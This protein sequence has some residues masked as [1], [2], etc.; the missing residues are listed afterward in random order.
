MPVLSISPFFLLILL[1]SFFLTH[2]PNPNATAVAAPADFLKLPL[3]HKPPFSSPSQSLSSDTHR[4]SL[5]FS[6]PNPTLKSPLIS[7]A[8]TGSGQYFVDIRLGTPPQSLLLVAD[9]GSDLVWVKCSACRNCSHHP[10]SSAFLPRHSSSFSPFHCFDPHCRLLPHAPHHLCNHTRL[11]SPCRFLYSYADGS[12]SSGFF[13]KETTTLKSL[14]GSEIHLKGLSFGCGFRISGPSV[15]GAQFNGA[16]G[17]MGLGRG[18]ISFSSQL[19]RR[20]GNKFSYCLMD[21]TLSPPPTSFLM[22][23]GGLH[24][25]P[26][27]NA[28]KISYTPLQINPLSPTFYYITIHSITIDGVKLPINPAVWEIDEQGN[29]GTV[30]D[31]G[32]TL[33]YLTKTAYEEVLKS[34]RR[35]VKLP[36]AAELTPGFDLCVN[37]SGESR[38]PSLPRL[39]FRLGGGAVFAPPPRNYFLETEEG[40]M[41]LAIRAVESGNGFSVIGNLMQQGF[42]LE[43]DK[44]E[45]RL[46]FTRRGCGLP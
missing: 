17:V 26:L 39:R 31:S 9:T 14:S 5:L 33:T 29:G 44:E 1:F 25:L 8:S 12:L 4:L 7:G 34:V 22:I 38:R 16:R 30:V 10:P 35:R 15:S 28:T 43:F 6:R 20:F 45:S 21:Y 3:L 13:S 2:L 36:N 23:G 24:S 42:L 18:S 37:A 46:G 41:C 32:T 11:H 19:G 40:V 27:T